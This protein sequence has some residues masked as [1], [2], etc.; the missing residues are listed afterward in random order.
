MPILDVPQHTDSVR[1]MN[2]D[3]PGVP[4]DQLNVDLTRL[5]RVM[6][7]GGIKLLAL[8]SF[9][10][11][12]TEYAATHVS[13][14]PDGTISA[15]KSKVA[16]KARLATPRSEELDKD[17]EYNWRNTAVYFNSTGLAERDTNAG[18]IVKTLD[19]SLRANLL[20][21]IGIGEVGPRRLLRETALVTAAVAL[22]KVTPDFI[23][24]DWDWSDIP[25]T[26][27]TPKPILPF[28]LKAIDTINPKTHRLPPK[29]STMFFWRTDR[30]LLAS[31][32]LTR[33][34]LTLSSKTGE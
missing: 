12:G 33:R 9:E 31:R 26:T 25:L 28:A 27:L 32:H 8:G 34:I 23:L 24:P 20:A 6:H 2:L 5:E 29:Y 21:D 11:E 7:W 30:A 1:I 17:S 18:A 10:G 15:T 19:K 13:I 22:S 14:N 3:L 4:V 16:S